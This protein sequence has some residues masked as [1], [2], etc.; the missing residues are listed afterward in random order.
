MRTCWPTSALSRLACLLAGILLLQ[1]CEPADRG[2]EYDLLITGGRVID[3]T[4]NPWFYADVGVRGDRIVA[5]GDLS[6]ATASRVLA[7]EGRTVTPGFIDLHSHAGEG[8]RSLGHEDPENRAAPNM[9]AQG[10]TTLVVNQDGRSP[11]PILEQRAGFEAAGIGPNAILL[12]GHGQLRSE[13]MGDDFRR[14]ATAA[15]VE[16]MRALLRQGLAEGAYGMSAGHEYSP[17]I[18]STTDEV[19]SLV[20]EIAPSRGIYVVHERSSG[21]EPM[22]WWP[23]QDP[24]GAPTMEDSVRETIEVAERSGVNSVQTHIKARGSHYWGTGQT[25][26]RMIQEARDRGVPIWADAYSYNTTGSDGS[27]VLIPP[28]VRR[29]AQD[30]ADQADRE[31]ADYTSVLRRLLANPDTAAMIRRDVAHEIRRRGGAQNLLVLEYPV[32]GHVG[33]NLAELAAGGGVSPV[34]MAIRLQ[35][36]GDATRAG[37]GRL[38]GFSLSEIDLDVFYAQPWVATASDAGITRAEDGST[39]PRYYGTFPRRIRRFAI[40]KGI[41]TVEDAVRS[42]TSLPAQILGLRNRGLIREG[43]YADLVVLD[44]ERVRDLATALEPHQY[45]EGIDF[46]F[47]NGTPVIED[48]EHTWALPG[49]VITPESGQR[50]VA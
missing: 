11:W 15:E 5:V 35:L 42:M 41:G 37:G 36:R 49:M 17:M 27:T 24:P 7:A 19:A 8:R 1:A 48:G 10:A 34:E 2:E 3:G 28:L 47:V 20:G 13:V 22:W 44:L 32:D 6:G 29:I 18:W 12:V 45:P 14:E 50:P 25:L 39:H 40:E 4:G 16:Q 46:V 43:M 31:D 33:K 9:I 38:R 30:E 23:S 21:P 26:V